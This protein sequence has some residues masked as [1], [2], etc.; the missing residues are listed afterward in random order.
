MAEIENIQ[1][2]ARA[3]EQE[4]NREHN[5]EML[6]NWGGFGLEVG[7][8]FVPGFGGAK[9][10]GQVTKQI[11]PKVGRKIAKEIA[12]GTLKGI[13]QGAAEGFG[14]GLA[15][16]ENPLKT[17]AQDAVLGTALGAGGG[18]V[19]G[20]FIDKLRGLHDKEWSYR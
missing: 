19:G 14:R 3:K 18:V 8:A 9:L 2:T 17:A 12:D 16:D 7:S 11:A 13:S 6:K 10:A 4:I 5:L 1:K 15:N 20:K